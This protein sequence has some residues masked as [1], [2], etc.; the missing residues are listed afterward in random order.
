MKKAFLFLINIVL[1]CVSVYSNQIIQRED[2]ADKLEK[3]CL[4]F[5]S[6]E[7]VLMDEACAIFV[8]L[9]EQLDSESMQNIINQQT[10][11][12]YIRSAVTISILGVSD[13]GMTF[14]SYLNEFEERIKSFLKMKLTA[15]VCI[16][17]GDYL[18]SKLSWNPDSFGIIQNLPVWYKRALFLDKG[19]TESLVDMAMWYI[20]GMSENTSCW[21]A[22]IK[23]QEKYIDSLP[24]VKR[25]NAYIC[26]SI[27]Y[28][29]ICETKKG[30]DYLE[31]ARAI[32]P[33]NISVLIIEENYKKGILGW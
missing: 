20:F 9:T 3:I 31:C 24:V 6:G 14:T 29:K 25:I 32:A 23:Q 19:N 17:Y 5:Y 11:G 26:Y 16:A 15:D 12:D 21:I 28:M 27:F 30:Y 2:I 8:F 18:Y 1:F 13:P 10:V 33:E 4:S 22:F 7:A